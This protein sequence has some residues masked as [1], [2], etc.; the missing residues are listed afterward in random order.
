MVFKSTQISL[1]L[2]CLAHFVTHVQGSLSRV[3]PL[4]YP[5]LISLRSLFVLRVDLDDWLP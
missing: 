4:S 2:W 3:R 5:Y 1:P